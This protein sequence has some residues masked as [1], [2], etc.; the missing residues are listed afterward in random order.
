MIQPNIVS[1][2]LYS[3]TKT[4]T[5]KKSKANRV[6][7]DGVNSDGIRVQEQQHTAILY[8]CL[9]DSRVSVTTS[10]LLIRTLILGSVVVSL[11]AH[12]WIES[13]SE[14]SNVYPSTYTHMHTHTHTYTRAHT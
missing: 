7:R 6:L 11:E 5:Q 13:R 1:S 14:R 9:V 10:A 3:T 2:E 8:S 12:A 4:Y